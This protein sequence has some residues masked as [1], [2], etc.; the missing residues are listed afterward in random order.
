VALASLEAGGL[1]DE[2]PRGHRLTEAGAAEAARL[3]AAQ[4]TSGRD[5]AALL[6]GFDAVNRELKAAVTAWQL[7]TIDGEPVPNDH[8]DPAHDSAVLGR[9]AAVHAQADAWLAQ[10]APTWMLDLFRRRL[11][12]AFARVEAGDR[13][14]ITSPLV[15]SYHSVW[16]ELHE[17]LI[18]LAG[19]TR[20]GEAAAGRAH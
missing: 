14:W 12:R 18:R 1:A 6:D 2:G 8:R 20:A 11:S 10:D 16:F 4:R 7:R 9:L 19:R 5:G 17:H 3:Y 15:D 13:A